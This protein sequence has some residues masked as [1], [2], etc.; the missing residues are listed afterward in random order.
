V[1]LRAGTAQIP[2]RYNWALYERRQPGSYSPVP[3]T[4]FRSNLPDWRPTNE[5]IVAAKQGHAPAHIM[6]G[7]FIRLPAGPVKGY[8]KVRLGS[9]AG[10]A[11][12][13]RLCGFD[14]FDG[15]QS[16]ARASLVSETSAAGSVRNLPFAFVLHPE[17]MDSKLE[18]RMYCW[19][20]TDITVESVYLSMP[21]NGS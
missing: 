19:G 20:Q 1:K 2:G 5:Y 11:T 13:Q 12:G 21:S 6:W 16:L 7:P 3:T 4:G 14:V 15:K 18:F 17:Q 9:L 8:V 10:I